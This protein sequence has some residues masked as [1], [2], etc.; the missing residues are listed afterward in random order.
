MPADQVA[1]IYFL[2]VG[3]GTSQVIA[4]ADGSLVIID[5]G[6][7][8]DALVMLLKSIKFTK[9][10]AV[11]LSHW[12]DDHVNGTPALL[13]NFAS[14]IEYFYVP[15][16]QPAASIRANP[17]YR[18]ITKLAEKK[19]FFV[20]RLEYRNVDCGKIHGEADASV[21]PRLSVQYPNF[22]ESVDVQSQKD[23]NQGSGI[24]LLEFGNEKVLFPGDAGKKAFK[25]LI[26]RLGNGPISC[27]IL[28]APHHSGNLSQGSTTVA[29]FR[30]CYHWL[31]QEVL[32]P[33][34]VV[35][36]AGTDNTYDHPKRAHLL[37]AVQ[38][39]ATIICTQMTPQCHGDVYSLKPSLLPQKDEYPAACSLN[40]GVGCGGTVVAEL[41]SNGVT[42]ERMDEHQRKVDDL[43]PS[44]TPLCRSSRST[45]VL[46]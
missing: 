3:Q 10:R 6:A 8:A 33:V 7:S 18:E 37:E 4:F 20:E 23:I 12:H 1:R 16:D 45:T 36:S 13:S 43:L 11:I 9:I 41:R 26:K 5:C 19:K 17:I 39:G 35:V 15:Q 38:S 29:G 27:N 28:A 31:Y 34:Y 2:D 24:L 21:G 14:K 46:V 32:K 25:A 22:S 40:S 30:D 44:Q 42:I